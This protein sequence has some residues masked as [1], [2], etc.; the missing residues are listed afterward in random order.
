MVFFY[1]VIKHFI[2]EP[3]N[4]NIQNA[5]FAIPTLQNTKKYSTFAAN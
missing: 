2:Y 4:I 1:M 5:I 3:Q